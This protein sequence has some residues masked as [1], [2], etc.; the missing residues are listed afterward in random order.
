MATNAVSL[1]TLKPRS[2][3]S[4]GTV[5]DYISS[6]GVK[7]RLLTRKPSK[8]KELEERKRIIGSIVD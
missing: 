4:F 5:H 6:E 2:E 8:E 1:S 3:K 7:E